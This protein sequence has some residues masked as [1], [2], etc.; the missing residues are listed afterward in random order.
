[1]HVNSSGIVIYFVL[2]YSDR[3]LPRVSYLLGF[4]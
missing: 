1:M 2:I 3:R 4:I